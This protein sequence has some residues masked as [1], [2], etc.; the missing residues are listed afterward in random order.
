MINGLPDISA[1]IQTGTFDLE[2]VAGLLV[3]SDGFPLPATWEESPEH[4][5]A[6]LH[7]MRDLLFDEGIEAYFAHLRRLQA[8]DDTLD[9]YPRFKTHDDSTGIFIKLADLD[10]E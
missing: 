5:E 10:A 6:R 4:T 2:P 7:T 3:C 8:D 9:R 1:Y